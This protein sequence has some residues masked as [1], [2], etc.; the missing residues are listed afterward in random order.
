MF[1]GIFV[2]IAV[3]AAGVAF[4]ETNNIDSMKAEFRQM[5]E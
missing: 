1:T 4:K 5:L 2:S 3:N